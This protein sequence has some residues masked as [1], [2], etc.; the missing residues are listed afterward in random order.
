MSATFWATLAVIVFTKMF[1]YTRFAESVKALI[2]SMSVSVEAS[3]K[4]ALEKY[5]EITF[6]DIFDQ[7]LLLLNWVELQIIFF[8]FI[9]SL[10]A[11]LLNLLFLLTYIS[12]A[13]IGCSLLI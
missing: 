10:L 6:F 13:L 2:N 12:I 3:A 11:I 4:R 8:C 1:E 5:V 9:F 7:F